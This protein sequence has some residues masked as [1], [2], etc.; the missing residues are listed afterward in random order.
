MTRAAEAPSDLGLFAHC[1]EVVHTE[2][3]G[4]GGRADVH[5]GSGTRLSR[6]R[7]LTCGHLFSNDADSGKT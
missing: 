4:A 3:V 1:V 6:D 2:A 5:Y 7:V